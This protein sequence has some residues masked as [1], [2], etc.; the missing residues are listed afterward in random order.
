[1]NCGSPYRKLPKPNPLFPNKEALD[2]TFLILNILCFFILIYEINEFNTAAND[3][4]DKCLIGLFGVNY[5]FRPEL[6]VELKK[7]ESSCLRI[8]HLKDF[9]LSLDE[10]VSSDPFINLSYT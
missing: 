5:T 9:N 10:L 6:T 4:S 1:M 3:Y 7:N 8:C 2:K